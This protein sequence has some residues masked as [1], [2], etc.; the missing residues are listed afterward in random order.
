MTYDFLETLYQDL[1]RM[2]DKLVVKR[3]DLARENET[4]ESLA[5][6][7]LYYACLTGSRY[8]YNFRQFDVDILN[9]YLSPAEVAECYRDM[10]KIPEKLRPAIVEEQAQRVINSYEETNEYYRALAGLPPKNDRF[11]IYVTDYA[12]IPS[13]VP[14]HQL[15][16]EQIAHLELRGKLSEL[17]EEYPS[18]EYLNYLGIYRIDFVTARLAKPFEILRL[19]VPTNSLSQ[20]MFED[21][22]YMARRYVMGTL[23]NRDMFT[24]KTLYE[25]FI[26]LLMITLAMRNTLVPNEAEYLNFEE[27]LNAILESYGFL[28]YFEDFPFTFKRRLVLALD[29]I[30]SVKGT[31]GVLVDIC[32]IF[33]YENFFANRYYLMKTYQKDADGNII[34][35]DD[36]E[37]QYDLSFIKAQIEE[38]DLNYAEENIT[39]YEV[40]TRNDYLWQLTEQEKH[41]MMNEDFNI[42]MSKYIGIE[43]AYDVSSLTFEVCY[44]I[45]LLLQ[46]RDNMNKIWCTN[47]YALGGKCTAYTM[48]IFLL[49]SL[50]KRSG[51]DG[52]IIYEPQHIAEILRFNYGDIQEELQAIIDKYELQVD[53]PVDEQLIPGYDPVQLDR[54]VGSLNNDQMVEVYVNNRDLYDAILAEMHSTN[55][56][57][58]YIALSNA[59]DCMYI[60]AM[61]RKDFV[62]GDGTNANTYMEML[63]SIEPVLAMKLNALD[64]EDDWNDLDRMI[65]YTL[66]KLEELFDSPELKYLF[67][68]TPNTYGTLISRYLRI[69]INVFKASSVQLESINI[70]FRAGDK[71]PVRVI[72]Q[73]Q[74]HKD[75]V[76]NETIHVTDEI[77]T[78]RVIVV[79]DVVAV[80][81]KV[82][83]NDV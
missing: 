20:K 28:R 73:K 14:I 81:D 74:V 83:V 43:A 21:E 48:I 63:E 26:G 6:F 72:E 69:A 2:I 39:D 36:P 12:D 79:N 49:A 60:S 78:H 1:L 44:F 41:D 58:K 22:Y 70:F 11:W 38:H 34:F 68:N 62:K 23:Y 13:D 29:K 71:E 30:L 77:A 4:T 59:K 76:I 51:F 57:R 9:K 64:R 52:N 3:S 7:D 65:L 17:Q 54:P 56:I 32:H 35:S 27:I 15:N 75:L 33:S 25:P 45:N 10:N 67:L 31:D 42:M 46:S 37:Q 24:N 66:E 61:E 82:Y 16:D 50:S 40:V 8:F 18:K 55:D 19:G 53:V 47:M 5:S 80:G